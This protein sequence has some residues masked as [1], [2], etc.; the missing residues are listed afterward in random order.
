MYQFNRLLLCTINDGVMSVHTVL[1]CK[2]SASQLI[3]V[4]SSP[5]S[6]C[7]SFLPWDEQLRGSKRSMRKTKNTVMLLH[8]FHM[9]AMILL[10]GEVCK[11]LN[12]ELVDLP[13]DI[14]NGSSVTGYTGIYSP[15]SKPGSSKSFI[16]LANRQNV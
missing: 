4:S 5:G 12:L 15:L 3:P 6:T 7:S 16:F 14:L 2:C 10:K 8:D 13:V 9:V 1:F 11:F